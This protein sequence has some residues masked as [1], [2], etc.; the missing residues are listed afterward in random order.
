MRPRQWRQETQ[1][2]AML[3]P[4]TPTE[5]AILLGWLFG[6]G[7]VMTSYE[8]AALLGVQPRRARSLLN[9]ASRMVPIFRDD[10]GR[11]KVCQDYE[12]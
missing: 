10:D 7:K 11:W 1:T 2:S 5:R 4:C 6:R 8:V 12:D 3:D 9:E